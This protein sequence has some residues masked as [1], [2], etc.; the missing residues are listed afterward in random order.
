M[1]QNVTMEFN[2]PEIKWNI[3]GM[4]VDEEDDTIMLGDLNPNELIEVP[5]EIRNEVSQ[6][7]VL[8]KICNSLP[9]RIEVIITW[10]DEDGSSAGNIHTASLVL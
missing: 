3:R 4:S 6:G 10:G 7:N 1:A 5:I 8:S 9:G 2:P